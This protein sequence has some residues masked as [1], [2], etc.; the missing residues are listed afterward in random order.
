MYQ[1]VVWRQTGTQPRSEPLMLQPT[2]AYIC[3]QALVGLDELKVIC[4][5]IALSLKSVR[6][7][8]QQNQF[9]LTIVWPR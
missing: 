3:N 9:D 4:Q 7:I 1:A 6:I 5:H 2:D 8:S